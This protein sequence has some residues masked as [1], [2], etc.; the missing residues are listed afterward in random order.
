MNAWPEKHSVLVLDN[1]RI[2]HN[3]TLLELLSANSMISLS[4]FLTIVQPQF[5]AESLLLF[6]PPY[7]PDL[8]PI[9]ESFSTRKRFSPRLIYSWNPDKFQSKP[10]CAATVPRCSLLRTQS[11]RSR[12]RVRVSQLRWRGIGSYMQDTSNRNSIHYKDI[13]DNELSIELFYL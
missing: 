6:L 9:E 11:S 13:F 1:C 5:P 2:H 4:L 7:S 8:N 10:I 12:K 3:D